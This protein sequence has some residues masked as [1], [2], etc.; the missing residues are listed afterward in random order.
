MQLINYLLIAKRWISKVGAISAD[1]FLIRASGRLAFITNNIN[2]TTSVI[3]F[4]LFLLSY[5][6]AYIVGILL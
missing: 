5:Y 2:F 1:H 3:K 6:L 4:T